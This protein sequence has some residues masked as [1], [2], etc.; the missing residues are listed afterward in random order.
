MTRAR[1]LAARFEG[2]KVFFLRGGPGLGTG[3]T[4]PGEFPRQ[5]HRPPNGEH[6]DQVDVGVYAADLGGN[7][8]YFTNASR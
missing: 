6:D 2:R 5:L 1:T 8:F 3:P 4:D 7:D